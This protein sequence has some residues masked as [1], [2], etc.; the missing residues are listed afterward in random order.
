MPNIESLDKLDAVKAKLETIVESSSRSIPELSQAAQDL[1]TAVDYAD[2]V[3]MQSSLASLYSCLSDVAR[4]LIEK[5]L[6]TASIAKDAIRQAW[7]EHV[8]GVA[9]ENFNKLRDVIESI[10]DRRISSMTRVSSLVEALR[11]NDH[12]VENAEEL[13]GC[14]RDLRQ[15]RLIS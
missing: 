7:K 14:I 3:L 2:G 8:N 1:L 6:E 5:E 13:D 15:F 12:V 10:I 9:C 11:D 4:R